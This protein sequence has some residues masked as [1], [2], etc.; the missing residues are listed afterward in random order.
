MEGYDDEYVDDNAAG[1][2]FVADVEILPKNYGTSRTKFIT[3]V[4]VNETFFV[5]GEI[6]PHQESYVTSNEEDDTQYSIIK[7]VAIERTEDLFAPLVE[8]A[9]TVTSSSSVTHVTSSSSSSLPSSS[10]VSSNQPQSKPSLAAHSL[11]ADAMMPL[12]SWQPIAAKGAKNDDKSKNVAAMPLSQEEIQF[13]GDLHYSIATG[14]LL[15]VAELTDSVETQEDLEWII[16]QNH[17]DS[18][19][20]SFIMACY[21]GSISIVALLISKG[22]NKSSL[23]GGSSA[24][25]ALIVAL[26]Q[27]HLP[28]AT[29]L[30]A[31][32]FE[33]INAIEK[34]ES[35]SALHILCVGKFKNC[36]TSQVHELITLLVSKGADLN[37]RMKNGFTPIMI[38]VSESNMELL[39]MLL[40]FPTLDLKLP[41]NDGKTVFDIASSRRLFQ[42]TKA[43]EGYKGSADNA[44]SQDGATD[45]SGV[46]ESPKKP[47]DVKGPLLNSSPEKPSP[48]KLKE[49]PVKKSS[50]NKSAMTSQ[51][52]SDYV[53]ASSGSPTKRSPK[54]VNTQLNTGDLPYIPE[55]LSDSNLSS[56]IG[57]NSAAAGSDSMAIQR[58]LKDDGALSNYYDEFG[59]SIL[60]TACRNGSLA[61]AALLL[62]HGALIDHA[63]LDGTT[64]LSMSILEEKVDVVKMLISKSAD[65]NYEEADMT[66]LMYACEV[67]NLSIVIALIEAGAHVGHQVE[68]NGWTALMH[69]AKAGSTVVVEY[70]MG[71]DKEDQH[72]NLVLDINAINE[73]GMTA[74]IIA[75]V[76]GHADVV[77]ILIQNEARVNVQAIDGSTAIVRACKLKHSAVAILLI[78]SS[79][80]MLDKQDSLGLT[81]LIVSVM[82]G[83][84]EV[85]TLL[86]KNS[87]KLNLTNAMGN[88]AL[89]IATKMGEESVVD[90]LASYGAD[91]NVANKQGWTALLI[92]AEKGYIRILATLLSRGASLHVQSSD[93][94]TALLL[95]CSNGHTDLVTLLISK[96]CDCEYYVPLIRAA[97]NDYLEIVKILVMRGVNINAENKEGMTAF[98]VACEKGFFQ[99]AAFLAKK[100]ADMAV[101]DNEGITPLMRACRTENVN[102]VEMIAGNRV[103]LNIQDPD[104]GETVLISACRDG[105]FSIVELLVFENAELEIESMDGKTALIVA[106]ESNN[107]A[108]AEFLIEQGAKVD[109]R[110][111][112]NGW[113]ALN[114]AVSKRNV[115]AVRYL[116]GNGADMNPGEFDDNAKSPLGVAAAFNF[117]DMIKL[118]EMYGAEVHGKSKGN[119]TPLLIAAGHGHVEVVSYLMKSCRKKV[120]NAQSLDGSNALSKACDGAHKV[121]V[122]LLLENG[123]LNT[124]T[125]DVAGNTVAHK[126]CKVGAVDVAQYLLQG[127]WRRKE[128]KAILNSRAYKLDVSTECDMNLPNR[129]GLTPLMVACESNQVDVVKL[130]VKSPV[131]DPNFSSLTTNAALLTAVE[132]GS[133]DCV[134]ALLS[135]ETKKR[136]GAFDKTNIEIRTR[137]KWTPIIIACDRNY[138]QIAEFLC[139]AGCDVNSYNNK[140]T[141]ALMKAAERGQESV[142]NM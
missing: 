88:T 20:N 45:S 71:L 18:K 48:S 46:T 101:P 32:G 122:K 70:I 98:N 136:S 72:G 12:D 35:K 55:E 59:Q 113:T 110:T 93:N 52:L 76:G 107:M 30:I 49:S 119:E 57:L 90:M 112:R 100:G 130:L 141:T 121:V 118:L 69:A 43:L 5:D 36:K 51:E 31:R 9:V 91:V 134:V 13:I 105:Y 73:V 6:L 120:L 127:S 2:A 132:R 142:L 11:A 95:A 87:C 33:D 21:C 92:A 65:V 25:T 97:E 75:S 4:P 125:V 137:S 109:A 103:N 16:D 58:I 29:M 116:A 10:A 39:Q 14:N 89:M 82:N 96:G 117:V 135:A 56:I 138:E 15:E 67:G 66:P 81:A 53:D 27:S 62:S 19:M 94:D 24:A 83:L 60:M 44:K 37:Q 106:I 108:I 79:I 140:R 74:L 85:A 26:Q 124:N 131:V 40:K 104:T 84:E 8:A 23:H 64:A 114:M 3:A 7:P 63:A 50:P 99:L 77:S 86:V 115:A 22:C 41:N 42:V 78:T 47:G 126:V 111:E 34:K 28:L 133:Y 139:K 61:V 68:G 54:P 102:I 1:S 123:G 17:P 129:E 128:I 80:C 38:A